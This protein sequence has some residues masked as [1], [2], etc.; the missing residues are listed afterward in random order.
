MTEN[1]SN[2]PNDQAL[3]LLEDLLYKTDAKNLREDLNRIFYGYISSDEADD[4]R[5]R[6]MKGSTYMALVNFLTKISNIPEI[7]RWSKKA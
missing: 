3:H 5:E 1:T 4:Q 7:D 2:T 6:N